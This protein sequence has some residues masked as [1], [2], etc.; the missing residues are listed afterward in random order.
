MRKLA[1]FTE[2]VKFQYGR[3]W[4]GFSWGRG[5]GEETEA[6]EREQEQQSGK[7]RGGKQGPGVWWKSS[8]VIFRLNINPRVFLAGICLKAGRRGLQ[9]ALVFSHYHLV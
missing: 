8:L 2:K 5:E 1:V 7:G 4:A 6:E 9:H 3:V